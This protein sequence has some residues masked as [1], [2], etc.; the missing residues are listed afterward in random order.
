M[1][2]ARKNRMDK[3]GIGLFAGLL[4]PVIVFIAAYLLGNKEVPFVRFVKELW[5]LQSLIQL[6]SLCVFAN[7][8]VFWIFIR[9]KY[10]KSA[11]GV[12]GATMFYALIVLI[13]KAF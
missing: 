2:Q 9:L 7:V 10:D 6:G 5:Q 13:T 3:T 12:L 4:L 1:Q 8:A 11:R